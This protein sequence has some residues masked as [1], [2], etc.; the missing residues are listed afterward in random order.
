V[1]VDDVRPPGNPSRNIAD[2]LTRDRCMRVED[3]AVAQ[4]CN[5][6]PRVPSAP[7]RADGRTV[8]GR[9]EILER[10]DRWSLRW[11]QNINPVAAAAQFPSYE[12]SD[13]LTAA[14]L[15]IEQAEKDPHAE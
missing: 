5:D 2:D 4:R 11:C 8:E 15:P 7:Q 1:L 3:V 14:Y 9:T 10:G 12:E 6:E 13:T